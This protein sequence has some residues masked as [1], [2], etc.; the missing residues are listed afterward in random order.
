[1]VVRSPLASGELSAYK[2]FSEKIGP[3]APTKYRVST[4]FSEPDRVTIS[5]EAQKL[6]RVEKLKLPDDFE[7]RT[8]TQKLVQGSQIRDFLARAFQSIL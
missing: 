1:M 7:L 3:S 8:L 2:G 6:S 5:E 4:S